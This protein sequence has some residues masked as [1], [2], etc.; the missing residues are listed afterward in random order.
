MPSDLHCVSYAARFFLLAAVT[1][2]LAI[3]AA[4]EGIRNSGMINCHS[5]QPNG[6]VLKMFCRNGTYSTSSMSAP[7]PST[8]QFIHLL[9]KTP[10]FEIG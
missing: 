4:M 8:A 7:E 5:A 3:S 10:I 2:Y 6:T 1:M 9:E